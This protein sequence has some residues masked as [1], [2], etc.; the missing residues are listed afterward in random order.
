[1]TEAKKLSKYTMIQKKKKAEKERHIA[2]EQH[3]KYEYEKERIECS[4]CRRMI[5]RKSLDEHKNTNMSNERV[6]I[7]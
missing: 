7:R 6:V 5:Q 3:V 4:L 2:L 1:M